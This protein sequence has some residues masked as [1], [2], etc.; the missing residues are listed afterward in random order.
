M[1]MLVI[2]SVKF[3]H[4]HTKGL[5]VSKIEFCIQMNGIYAN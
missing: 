1:Q 2:K 3:L 5:I 4:V